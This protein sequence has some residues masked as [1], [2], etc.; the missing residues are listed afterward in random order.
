MHYLVTVMSN[1]V[2]NIIKRPVEFAQ[3]GRQIHL[4]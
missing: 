2:Q 4:N 3:G 1:N